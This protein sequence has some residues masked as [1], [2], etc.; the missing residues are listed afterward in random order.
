MSHWADNEVKT[1]NFG[2]KRLDKRLGI[3]LEQLGDKP[4]ESIPVACGGWAETI[5]AF[6]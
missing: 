4:N 6:F 5:A 2:D 3:L 1:V